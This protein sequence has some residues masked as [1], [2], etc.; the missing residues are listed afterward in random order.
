[1]NYL[2]KIL[3]PVVTKPIPS[4]A[5]TAAHEVR[6]PSFFFWLWCFSPANQK[7]LEIFSSEIT[8]RT[9]IYLE[10]SACVEEKEAETASRVIVVAVTGSDCAVVKKKKKS[11]KMLI[12]LK[13]RGEVKRSENKQFSRLQSGSGGRNL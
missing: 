11:V 7:P 13:K 12:F 1:M 3:N 9:Q 8:S 5:E 2:I 10:Q 6:E 4:A